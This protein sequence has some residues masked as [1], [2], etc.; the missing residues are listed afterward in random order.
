[1]IEVG[2]W[3]RL[4]RIIRAN[5]NHY[6]YARQVRIEVAKQKRIEVAKQVRVRP[7]TRPETVYIQPPRHHLDSLQEARRLEIK[8]KSKPK[9]VKLRS[10]GLDD[11]LA[12]D[13]LTYQRRATMASMSRNDP[14]N[15]YHRER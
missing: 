12:Q 8:A 4:Y 5:V 3:R 15:Y 7:W 1:M 2:F 10:N 6:R 11:I 9:Q 13:I 14:H